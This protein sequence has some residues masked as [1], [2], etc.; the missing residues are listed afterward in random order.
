[1]GFCLFFRGFFFCNWCLPFLYWFWWRSGLGDFWW[2][3]LEFFQWIWCVWI[4]WRELWDGFFFRIGRIFFRRFWSIF[5]DCGEGVAWEQAAPKVEKLVV[6]GEISLPNKKFTFWIR[7]F[8]KMQ[9]T[10]EPGDFFWIG[11]FTKVMAFF[12]ENQEKFHLGQKFFY[13]CSSPVSLLPI[14]ARPWELILFL[15]SLR[16]FLGTLFSNFFHFEF[17]FVNSVLFGLLVI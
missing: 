4:I 12:S 8:V 7:K 9:M 5:V 15:F 14:L 1:M 10:Y 11:K 3:V 16:K 6:I 2:W 17:F 13:F